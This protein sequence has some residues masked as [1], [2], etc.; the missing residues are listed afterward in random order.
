MNWF[1]PV[2]II[3]SVVVLI[4]GFTFELFDEAEHPHDRGQFGKWS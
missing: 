1:L 3:V 4:V 2:F